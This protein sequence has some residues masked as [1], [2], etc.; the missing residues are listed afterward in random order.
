MCVPVSK[1]MVNITDEGLITTICIFKAHPGYSREN[2]AYITQA[3]REFE[4][5]R[6]QFVAPPGTQYCGKGKASTCAE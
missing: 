1:D 3:R 4:L 5:L 2:S 6:T